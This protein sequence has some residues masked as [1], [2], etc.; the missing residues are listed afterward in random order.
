MNVESPVF[1]GLVEELDYYIDP[2]TG[3]VV[4]TRDYLLRRGYCCNHRCR[5]CPYRGEEKSATEV[6]ILGV[7]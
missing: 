7:G 6:V 3:R 4:L 1:G 2:E 5:E